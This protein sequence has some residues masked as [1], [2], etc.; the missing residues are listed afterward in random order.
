MVCLFKSSGFLEV[1]A[2]SECFIKSHKILIFNLLEVTWML[3]IRVFARLQWKCLINFIPF[4][5]AF[6]NSEVHLS[7]T[8]M[9][10]CSSELSFRMVISCL[11]RFIGVWNLNMWAGFF[12][13]NVPLTKKYQTYLCMNLFAGVS[14]SEL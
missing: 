1:L 11:A 5:F 3:S 10:I 2:Y 14:L 7:Q 9:F 6:R 8:Y 12:T 4:R 13:F